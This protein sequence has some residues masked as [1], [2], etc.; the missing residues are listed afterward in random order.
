LWLIAVATFGGT[1]KAGSLALLTNK[2]SFTL[3]TNSTRKRKMLTMTIAGNVGKDAV[4]RNTQGGDPVLGF[5][6]AVDNGKDKNGNKRDSTWVQCSIWGK[7]ADSLSSHIV[8]GTKL[9]V[10]G[11][12]NV[13]V[14]EGKGRL[15]LSVQDLTFMG[16]T[17][18]RN[19]QE[20]QINSRSDLD[21]E[22]PF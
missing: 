2:K 8:K 16:G 20:P 1:S 9:V 13:D 10:S 14:Y 12:P 18:E 19:E 22:I 3:H 11:R 15:T 21:D 5:S 7:R 6:I 4:L 17:K